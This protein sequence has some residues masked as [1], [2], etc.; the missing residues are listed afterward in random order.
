MSC[1]TG[2][3]GFLQSVAH[4]LGDTLV[5]KKASVVVVVQHQ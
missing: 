3:L 2:A 1:V 4:L 5:R